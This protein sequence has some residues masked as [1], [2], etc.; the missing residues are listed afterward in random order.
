MSFVLLFVCIFLFLIEIHD[1]S[2]IEFDL[3]NLKSGDFFPE[4][5]YSVSE[6]VSDQAG[7]TAWNWFNIYVIAGKLLDMYKC[8]IV[9]GM[10]N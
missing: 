5:E 9:Y 10:P 6:Q 4:G 3:V 8:R 7:N 2:S 1:Y